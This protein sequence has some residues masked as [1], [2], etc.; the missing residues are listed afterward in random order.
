MS[1]TRVV[2]LLGSLRADSLNRRIAETLRDQAPAGTVVEIAEG[3]GELPFYNE[4][5]DGDEAPAAA[6]APPRPGRRRRPRARRDPGVQRHDAGRAQ[7]RDRLALP[8]LRRG[9][10][11]GKPFAAVG[12]TP[13]PYGG[14]WA[15]DDARRSAGIAGAVVLRATSW[16][17][18]RR[19]TA[20]SWPTPRSSAGC[21]A[22][23]TR[24][25]ASA[26]PPTP[27]RRRLSEHPAAAR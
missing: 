10:L 9:A 18:S 11:R 25:S 24:W 1:D 3:L 21:S 5:L 26:H 17:P 12:A 8:P 22:P 19:S 15:H 20:T 6:A 16:S 23:S 27:D 14:K 2:V 7:Q 4:E 13:T